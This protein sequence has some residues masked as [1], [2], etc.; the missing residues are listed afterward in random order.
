MIG[1]NL[2]RIMPQS[3][4]FVVVVF[5]SL[6]CCLLEKA[7][8]ESLKQEAGPTGPAFSGRDVLYVD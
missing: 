7:G 1:T 6:F 3:V 2:E 8:T 4:I 5:V